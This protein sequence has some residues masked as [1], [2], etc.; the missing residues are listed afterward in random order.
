[1][2]PAPAR[3]PR[4]RQNG[5]R[6]IGARALVRAGGRHGRR[7]QESEPDRVY[8]VSWPAAGQIR[9]LLRR[10]L[11]FRPRRR[12]WLLL[13]AAGFRVTAWKAGSRSRSAAGS[14]SSRGSRGATRGAG[15]V[16]PSA[17]S[18]SPALAEREGVS[19]VA[20]QPRRLQPTATLA[21]RK[22]SSGIAFRSRHVIAIGRL[23][24]CDT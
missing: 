5:A 12:G 15:A 13:V 2:R 23:P 8:R 19:R 18:E 10:R 24:W 4:Y 17:G 20:A 22:K 7:A 21:S 6:A 9:R 14:T 11:D 1:M 3:T 16:G